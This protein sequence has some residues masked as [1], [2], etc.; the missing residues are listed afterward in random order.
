MYWLIQKLSSNKRVHTQ[1]PKH[2]DLLMDASLVFQDQD[3]DSD[4]SVWFPGYPL[5]TGRQLS[6]ETN[7]KNNV[8]P[9]EIP[10]VILV[11]YLGSLYWLIWNNP[12]VTWVGFHPRIPYMY[13]PTNKGPFFHCSIVHVMAFRTHGVFPPPPLA[14]LSVS[15]L[16]MSTNF[17]CKAMPE[18]QRNGT[19]EER[20]QAGLSDSKRTPTYP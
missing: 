15:S 4:D 19:F 17:I 8:V 13:N 1:L 11:G 5:L 20:F 10:W 3:Q 7:K 2:C 18:F 16:W 14:T 9:Y 6:H 12:Y